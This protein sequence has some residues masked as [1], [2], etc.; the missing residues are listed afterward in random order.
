MRPDDR[1]L[2]EEIRAHLAISVKERIDAGEEP[3]AARLAA[4]RELGYVPAIREEMRRVW[5][6]RWFDAAAALG[7]DMRL[8]LRS[9]LRA[10]G[11][12]ATVVVTLALGIGANAAIFSVVRGVLLRP[13]VNRGED[14]LIYIR[15]SGLGL[16]AENMTFSVP[17]IKDIRARATSVENFGE[18]STVEFNLVG[19]GEPR[20]V[21]SGVVDG[22]YFEVVGLR[23]QLGRLI[24]PTD[25][26][27]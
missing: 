21:E 26:G 15:Q 6:S 13:L 24:E 20:V 17:E 25:D 1:E 3:E 14:R 10:K 27:P 2:D 16:G 19:L 9:L 7:H 5:F 22:R 12:A 23:A 4:L 11:L 18:F 8:A